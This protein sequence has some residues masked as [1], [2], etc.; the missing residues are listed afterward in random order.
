[1][2]P[3]SNVQLVCSD[4]ILKFAQLEMYSA[5]L[6]GE[7]TTAPRAN[8]ATVTDA[9]DPVDF[10]VS[11]PS[12]IKPLLTIA[13][14]AVVQSPSLKPFQMCEAIVPPTAHRGQLLCSSP[15]PS[16]LLVN[17]RCAVRLNLRF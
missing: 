6:F 17:T 8:A 2:F 16:L 11:P 7:H 1:M 13:A 14:F 12:W 4:V 15:R 5:N 9:L 10:S 3:P